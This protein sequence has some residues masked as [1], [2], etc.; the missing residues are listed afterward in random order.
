MTSSPW[1]TL[2]HAGFEPL[3][4]ARLQAHYATQWLTRTARAYI[5]AKPDDSHTNLGWNDGF[6]GLT[7]HAFAGKTQLGLRFSDLTLALLDNGTIAQSFPLHGRNEAEAHLW[8]GQQAQRLTLSVDQL[9]TPLPYELPAHPLQQSGRYD[10]SALAAPLRELAAWYANG[11]QALDGLR[12]HLVAHGLRAPEVRLWP[13]HFDLDCLTVIGDGAAYAVPTMGAGFS[14]GDHYYEEPYFYISVY[15][16]PDLAALPK[17]D[18]PGHW[19]TEDFLAAVVPASRVLA[20]K[21]RQGETETFLHSTA[22]RIVKLL[23]DSA[24]RPN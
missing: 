7:T 11:F 3:R 2:G 1:R 6:D 22:D 23:D 18:P 16:R 14:G 8:L 12:Q 24:A 20:L 17:L 4:E 10:A 13:H 21:D 15:P 5:P 19:H 9:G